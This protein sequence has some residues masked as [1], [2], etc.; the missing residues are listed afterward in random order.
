MLLLFLLLFIFLV[1]PV[2]AYT[3]EMT[4]RRYA[5][6]GITPITETTKTYQWL[7][8]NLPVR[9]T[10]IPTITT[11]GRFLRENGRLTMESHSR[12]TWTDW[13]STLPAWLDSEEMW[14]RFWNGTV[15]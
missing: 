14:D 3:T 11:R 2:T 15:L 9:V 10:G 8:A 13:G 12:R 1:T 5:I 6:D 7:E 4:V